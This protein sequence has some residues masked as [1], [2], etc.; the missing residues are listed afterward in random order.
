MKN[1]LNIFILAVL[2]TTPIA[3]RLLVFGSNPNMDKVPFYK[4]SQKAK[5]LSLRE[6]V[7]GLQMANLAGADTVLTRHP[8]NN[9]RDSIGLAIGYNDHIAYRDLACSGTDPGVKTDCSNAPPYNG[10]VGRLTD[11]INTLPTIGASVGI[12]ECSAV[13]SSGSLTGTDSNGNSVTLNFQAPTH[14]IPSP[15]LNGG[16]TFSKRVE[17]QE[18][19]LG[20][21][22]KLAYEFN[23]GDSPALYIAINMDMGTIDTHAYTRLITVYTGPVSSSKNAMEI[24]MAEYSSAATRIRAADAI[25]IEYTPSSQDFKLWGVMNTNLINN[26]QVV[27]RAIMNGN[28]STGSAT[29]FYDGYEGVNLAGNDSAIDVT[30]TNAAGA[31]STASDLTNGAAGSP[32]HDFDSDL[33]T[34]VTYASPGEVFKKGCVDFTNPDVAPASSADCTGYPLA[35]VS[36]A[37]YIDGSGAWTIQWALLTLPTKLEVIP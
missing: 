23:C 32:L 25:R 13:P 18:T 9:L 17:F 27:S 15:W 28:Y 20:D 7:A 30:T 36:S 8:T 3:P 12:T 4:E 26:H 33:T 31:F 29:V 22:T 2:I 6:L 1:K 14:T 11:I 35:A 19:I 24:Y 5:S 10:I 34:A 16:A 21:V 37:P